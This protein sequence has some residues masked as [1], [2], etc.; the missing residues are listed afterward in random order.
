MKEKKDSWEKLSS[1]STIIASIFIPIAVVIIGNMYSSALKESETQV[2]YVELAVEILKE[3]PSDKKHNLRKWAVDLINNYS[4]IEIDS[5]T[6]E[7][8]LNDPLLK[9]IDNF[10]A[11]KYAPFIVGYVLESPNVLDDFKKAINSGDKKEIT[12]MFTEF[13]IAAYQQLEKRKKQMKE[14]IESNEIRPGHSQS[15]A[16]IEDIYRK[17]EELENKN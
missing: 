12:K 1:L 9:E 15:N 7:E 17:L 4:E 10:V 2:R 5:Q 13:M 3:K 6:R 16:E 11:E 14:P 8:L